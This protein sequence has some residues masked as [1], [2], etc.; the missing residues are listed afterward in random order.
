MPDPHGEDSGS[1]QT[2][3]VGWRPRLEGSLLCLSV[4]SILESEKIGAALRRHESLGHI[5][6]VLILNAD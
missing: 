3:G 5:D 4:K 2:R 6:H 1:P